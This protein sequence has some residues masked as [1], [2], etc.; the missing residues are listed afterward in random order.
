MSTIV[1]P[2]SPSDGQIFPPTSIPGVK[3]YRWDE[4]SSTWVLIPEGGTSFSLTV[5]A[6]TGLAISGPSDGKVLATTYNTLIDDAELSYPVGGAASLPA[7]E[8]KEKNIVEV[9]DAI[10][11]P[12]LFPSYVI[13]TLSLTAS[14]TGTKEVG[15]TITQSLSLIAVKND[16]GPFSLLKF[17]RNGSDIST[18]SGPTSSTTDDLPEQF[19]YENP[20]NPNLEY[21]ESYNDEFEVTEST[22][23]WTGAGTYSSGDPLK[24][25]KGQD[26]SRS[27]E[28]R[29]SSAPQLGSSINSSSVSVTGIYPFF[30]GKSA[31]AVSV[32][33]IAAAILS[34]TEN[35]VLSSSS[36][37]IQATFDA[38]EEFVWFAHP[39]SYPSKTRWYFT[40][41]NQGL[42]SGSG[43]ISPGVLQD[44]DSPDG[45]WSGQ[46]YKIYISNYQTNTTGS[47]QL[48]NS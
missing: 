1:F 4:S 25:N 41:L 11:F 48:R 39:A 46:S 3:Q 40:D 2:S 44:V 31:V 47:L 35:K 28:I 18:V 6:N 15:E 20:N 26:D 27:P 19:D 12:E 42:I 45:L 37:T 38:N 30:W 32:S 16:A 8:W 10:L 14:E 5:E 43:F 34:G 24:T 9:L 23:S 7:S 29:S 17:Q 33:D 22:T 36:G 13:P 21:T